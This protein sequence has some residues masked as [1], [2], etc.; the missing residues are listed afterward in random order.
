MNTLA[1]QF[2]ARWRS[3]R[4]L[5]PLGRIGLSSAKTQH[6]KRFLECGSPTA[7]AAH[8][9]VS[10]GTPASALGTAT[11]QK[12]RS[13]PELQM[14][15]HLPAALKRCEV[16]RNSLGK[17][18]CSLHALELV[19]ALAQVLAWAVPYQESLPASLGFFGGKT[20]CV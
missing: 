9:A 19:L 7:G 16:Q 3:S 13:E 1:G 2:C 11:F 20:V 18:S 14:T 12:S 15:L 6:S 10:W 8:T 5:T 17:A 4:R